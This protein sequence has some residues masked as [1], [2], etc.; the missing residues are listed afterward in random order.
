[1]GIL[2]PTR[3]Q[4]KQT[5]N[6][7]EEQQQLKN[8]ACCFREEEKRHIKKFLLSINIHQ[9]INKKEVIRLH[10]T[11]AQFCRGPSYTP[12]RAE[13]DCCQNV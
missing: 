10:R 4:R 1:V 7:Q 8:L 2:A 5:K 9:Q 3:T 13:R 6:A 11:H 12:Q